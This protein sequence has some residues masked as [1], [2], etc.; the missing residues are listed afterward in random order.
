MPFDVARIET[1]IGVPVHK[2]ASGRVGRSGVNQV[3]IEVFERGL[4]PLADVSARRQ[5]I[6]ILLLEELLFVHEIK[7]TAYLERI[8]NKVNS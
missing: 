2:K 7:N 1:D 4:P 3:D 6:E 8:K 5:H